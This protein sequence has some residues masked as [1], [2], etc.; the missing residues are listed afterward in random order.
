MLV[1]MLVIWLFFMGLVWWWLC[2]WCL[3]LWWWVILID[4][5]R[6]WRC[7]GLMWV[8][9]R[10]RVWERCWVRWLKSFWR[11]WGISLGGWVSWGLRGRILRGWLRG[12]YCRL[13]CWFWFLGWWKSWNR[14]GRSWG[15]CLRRVWS[16]RVGENGNVN[17][18]SR[19]SKWD[20]EMI[21][22]IELWNLK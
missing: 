22:V 1:M 6:W 21:Y 20:F 4:I 14:R 3:S 5:F 18:V 10:G 12:W 7:L 17:W 16:I 15:S 8:M 11:S 9:L 13:G 19:W 2:L